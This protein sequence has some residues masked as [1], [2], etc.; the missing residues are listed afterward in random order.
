MKPLP[1]IGSLVGCMILAVVFFCATGRA[2]IVDR[3]VANV[4]GHIILYSDLQHRIALLEKRMPSLNTNDPAKKSKIE[5]EVLQQLIQQ[6]L[7][8]EQA[9]QL[10]ITVSKA[11]VD[12]RLQS[13]LT[14]NHLT[15]EQLKA[16]LEANGD[17]LKHLRKQIK[18]SIARRELIQQV[19][20]SQVVITK[21]QV[22]AFLRSHGAQDAIA[23]Q[24]VDLALIALPF[25]ANPA[26]AKK[27]G[28]QLV[29]EL[30]SGADFKTLAMHYSKGPAA[31][32]GGN[33]G[34]MDRADIA[35]FLE[36][37]IKG[38]KK[39]Q[40]SKL[41]Q[42]PDGYYIVKILD[43][44]KNHISMQNAALRERVR[45][46]LSEQAMNRKYIKWVK[47]LESKAFI[48]ISL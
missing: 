13:L 25:G 45:Q 35:P 5:H 38:L 34:F 9:K 41:A 37:A 26:E 8:D 22:D 19:I 14:M 36:K 7:A 44:K 11:Q 39:G 31:Q 42:G 40:V 46:I 15:I 23:S 2:E 43:V 30:R 48:Q 47:G 10:G 3:I 27:T 16:K 12:A 6:K 21:E 20:K 32:A 1:K 18:D 17:T 28:E 4:N 33:V 29:K 24:Q